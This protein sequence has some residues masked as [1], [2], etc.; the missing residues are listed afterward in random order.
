MEVFICKNKNWESTG[1]QQLECLDQRGFANVENIEIQPLLPRLTHI[2]VTLP[3]T[4]I[5]SLFPEKY[6]VFPYVP[7]LIVAWPVIRIQISTVYPVSS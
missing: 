3:V 6:T 5:A 4:Q 1:S 2:Y 7:P